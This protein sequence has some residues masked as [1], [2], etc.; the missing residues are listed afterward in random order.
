MRITKARCCSVVV[1]FMSIFLVVA[2]AVGCASEVVPTESPQISMMV[3]ANFTALKY[4]AGAL[5][6]WDTGRNTLQ[7]SGTSVVHVS[8]LDNEGLP[9]YWQLTS[10]VH[11][12][13]QW[14]IK[15]KK[16]LITTV[17]KNV[18]LLTPPK[19]MQ[20]QYGMGI[21]FG[22]PFVRWY[23]AES[24]S[25]LT[26]DG[27]IIMSSSQ[28]SLDGTI[29]TVTEQSSQQTNASA[30]KPQTLSVAVPPGLV[31]M[32]V[33]YASGSTQ[34]GFVF[35]EA[36]P[37][38]VSINTPDSIWLLRMNGGVGSWVDCGD[39]SAFGGNIFSDQ[40]P[41]F[42]R[43]GFVLYFTHSH[44]KIGCIDTAA[45]SPSITVPENINT[46]LAKLWNTGPKD[47][48]GPIQAQLYSDNGVLII[49]YPNADWNGGY[50]YAVDASGAILGNLYVDKTSITSFDAEGRR[51]SWIPAPWNIL[52]PSLDLFQEHVS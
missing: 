35:V 27:E 42:A 12:V 11:I 39:L 25:F 16:P 8:N 41:S 1:A 2:L 15:N 49:G 10:P 26:T 52:F 33:L 28:K 43:V 31:H 17:S 48:E 36:A 29:M 24:E 23:A 18:E 51:G 21:P 13:Q 4:D 22:Q 9:L 5:L 45:A 19:G 3:V 44:G 47:A 40:T 30:P 32:V 6:L 20:Y 34:K 14:D 50:D 38:N 46:L 37:A 7:M